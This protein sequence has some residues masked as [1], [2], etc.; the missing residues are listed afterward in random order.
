MVLD[1][2]SI[3]VEQEAPAGDGGFGKLLLVRVELE[4][5]FL[6]E[7]IVGHVQ[8]SILRGGPPQHACNDRWPFERE[9]LVVAGV[10]LW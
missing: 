4:S 9:L 8:I 6:D 1:V 3:S 10:F 5:P 2:V 7:L